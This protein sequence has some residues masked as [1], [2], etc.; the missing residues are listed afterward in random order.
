M[1]PAGGVRTSLATYSW[2]NGPALAGGQD[3]VN[4]FRDTFQPGRGIFGPG[5][6]LVPPE[7]EK[8]RTWDFPV[9]WNTVYTPRSYEPISF[10]E[11]RGLADGHDITRLAIETRKNQIEKFDWVIR[12][13]DENDRAAD[14]DRRIGQLTEFWRSPN[15]E[16]PFATWLR[17]ALEDLLVLDAPAFEVRRNRGGEIIGL[18]VID[19]ATLKI[20]IDETGRRPKPP[21]PAYEQVIHGRPWRLLTADEL[22]YSPRNRRP[23]K[24]YGFSPVEQIVVTVN[25]GLR[26]QIMQLQHFTD[27]NVPPGLLN[28]PDGW[29]A[30]QIRQ[31]QEWFDAILSGNTAERTKLI[32]GPAGA[33]YQS[34]KEAPYKDDFDEWLARVICYAFDL[35]PNAFTK[36]INRATAETVQEAALSEGLA[37]LMGWV[38]RLADDVIQ[39]RMGHADLEFA[40]NSDRPL[41]AE[42]AS[43]VIDQK[44]RSGRMTLNEARDADGMDPVDGG[45]EPMIYVA[46]GPMLLKDIVHPNPPGASMA[47]DKPAAGGPAGPGGQPGEEGPSAGKAALPFRKT[48]EDDEGGHPYGI[49][50]NNQERDEKGR[51]G[52]GGAGAHAEPTTGG[53]PRDLTSRERNALYAYAGNAYRSI[54][55]ALALGKVSELSEEYRDYIH[56]IDSAVA[57]STL[58]E[59]KAVYRG[60]PIN[61]LSQLN[62]GGAK[63]AVGHEVKFTSFTSTSMSQTIAKVVEK[64]F[65][66]SGGWRLNIRVPKGAHA[67]DM[68]ATGTGVTKE[69]EILLGR[70]ARF[71]ITAIRHSSRTMSLAMTH[72]GLG[73]VHG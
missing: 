64:N 2:G 72:D 4:R 45:D 23:H 13:R 28:A 56:A 37:P 39:R 68:S 43:A 12:A 11:L 32:W 1:P 47:P 60:L 24:A 26:R 70:G 3:Q 27:G 59:D 6:P 50:P 33:K 73:P 62:A 69:R 38:K 16:D 34:F 30:E 36:Q 66:S 20:L 17:E 58:S 40:W 71:R 25:I 61:N 63:I 10:A 67:I 22:I 49:T 52:G 54:N 41:S 65:A 44:L 21:A 48:A 57:R 19:G 55:R 42:V 9:L 15:G 29:N 53:I 5:Y 51:Y 7:P 18:D 8:T 31:F 14:A 35:P 46:T